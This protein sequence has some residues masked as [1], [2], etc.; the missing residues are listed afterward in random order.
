MWSRAQA[1][2]AISDAALSSELAQQGAAVSVAAAEGRVSAMATELRARK[3][4]AA[5]EVRAARP[6]FDA[7]RCA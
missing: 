3:E 7:L 6:R 1:S 5:G 2:A 4:L